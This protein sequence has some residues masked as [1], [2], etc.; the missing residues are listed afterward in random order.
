MGG[1]VYIKEKLTGLPVFYNVNF[2]HGIPIG[3]LP[4]GVRVELDCENKTIT[5]LESATV[6]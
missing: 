6:I 3:I 2:G 5:F 1:K 4:I